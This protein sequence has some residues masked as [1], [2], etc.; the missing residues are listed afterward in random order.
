MPF[1]PNTIISKGDIFMKKSIAAL[2]I[3]AAMI[4]VFSGCDKIPA[5]E[6]L[7]KEN[8]PF[9][10]ELTGAK[11]TALRKKWGTPVYENG[12]TDIWE[13]NDGREIRYILAKYGD[14]GKAASVNVSQKLFAVLAED[15]EDTF[16]LIST[17]EN[18]KGDIGNLISC[19]KKDAF[20]NTLDI[21][22]GSC[23]VFQYSGVV[24]ESYPA[25]IAPVFNMIV[26]KEG[27]KKEAIEVR[28][29]MEDFRKSMGE[30]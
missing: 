2:L 3:C 17:D 14:N 23:V 19:S 6:D 7:L 5:K 12:N 26:L 28:R 1:D 16:Y 10:Q 27:S 29:L 13:Y 20:G 30:E 24:M 25:Q 4:L 11:K 8:D 9:P 15:G 21:K 22:P 18:F